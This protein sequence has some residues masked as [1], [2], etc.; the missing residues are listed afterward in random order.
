MNCVE[1]QSESQ[2]CPLWGL[3]PDIKIFGPSW[4]KFCLPVPPIS[5]TALHQFLSTAEEMGLGDSDSLLVIF[6]TFYYEI[7]V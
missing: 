1:A 7:F 3:N 5:S 4:K 2:M 6:L